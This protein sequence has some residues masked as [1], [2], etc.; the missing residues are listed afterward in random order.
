MKAKDRKR[1]LAHCARKVAYRTKEEAEQACWSV[2]MKVY[3]CPVASHW[4]YGHSW[5]RKPYGL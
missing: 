3:K 1:K 2:H 4:H 5:E